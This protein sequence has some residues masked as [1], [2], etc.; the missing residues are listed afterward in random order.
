M[1]RVALF[2]VLVWFLSL[3][4]LRSV[5]QWWRTGDA[6]V[7][8]FSG[9]VGSLEWNAGALAS[10]GMAAGVVAPVATLAA[11][12]GSALWFANDAIHQFGAVLVA[13]GIAGALAAQISMGNSWRIGVDARET[14]ELVTDGLFAWVRN[15][16]F[17]FILLTG[18]GLVLLLPTT[19]SLLALVLTTLGIEIQVRAVE[20]PYLEKTHGTVY[21]DYASRVGRL[22]PGV[23]RMDGSPGRGSH[24][25]G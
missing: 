16:I 12:P 15:P 1:P 10:L 17:S 25:A 7:R 18:A 5:I 23:G 4:V 13:A 6:G 2:L 21:R 22:V 8:G 24:A 20:E 11:W 19:L 9:R 14:T 3:F